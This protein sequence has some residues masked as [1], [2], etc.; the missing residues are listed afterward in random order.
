M[1]IQTWKLLRTLVNATY[2]FKNLPV[3]S[4]E[5]PGL[6]HRLDKETSGLI[7]VA[8]SNLAMKSL[9]DQFYNK[10]I[11][12]T[13]QALV[14]GNV[15]KDNGTIN[16]NIARDLKNRLKM[17]VYADNEIEYASKPEYTSPS[18]V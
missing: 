14:W 15:Q 16:A 3:N 13:Y 5:R 18:N 2:H 9:A 1:F 10:T 7:L 11:N 6:V 4:N 8:K 17:F 12:R